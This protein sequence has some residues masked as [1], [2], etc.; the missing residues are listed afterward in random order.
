[1]P[2]VKLPVAHL[3]LWFQVLPRNGH[4]KKNSTYFRP[5]TKMEGEQAYLRRPGY[6]GLRGDGRVKKGPACVL[7]LPVQSGGRRRCA[8]CPMPAL[9]S[10][11]C[12]ERG[13]R[14]LG[15]QIWLGLLKGG[16]WGAML[17]G[18]CCLPPPVLQRKLR[19]TKWPF[20]WF[21]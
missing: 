19:F 15:F 21:L 14:F 1:M 20:K 8:W 2:A 3:L 9:T 7:V 5:K 10:P 13:N 17:P 12:T 4:L 11:G 18:F 16:P 6:R